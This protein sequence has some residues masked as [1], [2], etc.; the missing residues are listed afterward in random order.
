[1]KLRKIMVEDKIRCIETNELI[2]AEEC[3]KCE[4]YRK[5]KYQNSMFKQKYLVCTFGD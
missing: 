4:H 2:T 3:R 1:M 5:P